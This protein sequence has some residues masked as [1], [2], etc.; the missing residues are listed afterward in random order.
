MS[1]KPDHIWK[2]SETLTLCE[3]VAPPNWH[4]QSGNYGFWLWDESRGM[5][6]AM[7]AAT[8][9]DAFVDAIEYYQN[10]IVKVEASYK[11]LRGRVDDFL[12]QCRTDN[13]HF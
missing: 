7:R 5:N 12:S 4:Y 11:T 13:A 2:L 6:L 1:K 8:E 10:Y 9:R 3:H